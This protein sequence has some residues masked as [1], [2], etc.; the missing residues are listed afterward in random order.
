MG[1][2]EIIRRELPHLSGLVI[3][4][5]IWTVSPTLT[6]IASQVENPKTKAAC[7]T[8]VVFLQALGAFRSKALGDWKDGKRQR[9]E[10]ALLAR[11]PSKPSADPATIA[12]GHLR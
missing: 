12:E 3:D 1:A 10:T 11:T 8:G 4:G 2:T 7:L 5:F 9:E 6:F